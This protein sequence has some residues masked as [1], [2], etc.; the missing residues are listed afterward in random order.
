MAA[1]YGE[2]VHEGQFAR[3]RVSRHRG[4]ARLEQQRVTGE[5][6]VLLRPGA[7]FVEGVA[8]PHSLQGRLARPSTARH[9]R[10]DRRRRAGFCRMLALPAMLHARA[11]KGQP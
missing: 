8:S 6:R 1:A 11:G 5:V 2:L 10:V 9:R 7:L 4:A 3:A